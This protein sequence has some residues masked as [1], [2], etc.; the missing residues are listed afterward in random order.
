MKPVSFRQRL[1][2]RLAV[3]MI[4]VALLSLLLT[5]AVQFVTLTRADLQPPDIERIV[6]QLTAQNPD[7]PT[8][9]AIREFPRRLARAVLS[10]TLFSV[11][12]SSGLWIYLAIRFARAIATP[13]EAVTAAS[14]KITGG[15]LGARAHVPVAAAGET[16]RLA[17]HFNEMAASLETYERERTEMIAAIAHEL[18]TPLAV[19][20]ARLEV[21]E[22]GIVPLNLSE[23]VRLGH[24][25]KLLTRLVDDLR[26]LSLADANR[27]SLHKRET[28]LSELVQRVTESF[29]ARAAE[30]GVRL[31]RT[32]KNVRAVVDPERLEQI[33]INLLDNAFKHTPCGGIVSVTL[34]TRQQICLT[35]QDTG[36]GFEGEPDHLF[37]RFYR[38]KDAP[39]GSGLGLAIVQILVEAHGGT[40]TA[41]NRSDGGASFEVNLP[42]AIT[43]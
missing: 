32:L 2:V 19:I 11:L 43:T 34:S 6:A 35:V 24:Q 29:E 18:R 36:S 25:T 42:L 41:K 26:T 40:V 31:E 17:E 16:V 30:G 10:T 21:L 39:S 4:S 28:N 22:E 1:V 20:Q 13:I 12:L 9:A 33:F 37:E 15:D 23:I 38:A 7:D 5:F 14:A 3:G 8:V 27:L